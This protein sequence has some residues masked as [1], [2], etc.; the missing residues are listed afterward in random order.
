MRGLREALLLHAAAVAG[1]AAMQPRAFEPVLLHEVT[2]HSWMLKQLRVQASGLSGVLDLY[3]PQVSES[4]WIGHSYPT[5]AGG[6]RA[7]YWLNGQLPLHHLLANADPASAEARRTGEGVD[8]Y[9]DYIIAHQDQGG[10]LGPGAND[11]S[12]A[13]LWARYYLLYTFA[14]RAEG[15]TNATQRAENSEAATLVGLG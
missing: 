8:K 4:V 14:L 12:G 9:M 7:T 5:F 3:W 6:E 2:P 11:T 15:T 1:A 13:L 10:W